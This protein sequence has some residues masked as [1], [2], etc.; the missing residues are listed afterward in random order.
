MITE[1]LN[2]LRQISE[3]FEGT[4]EELQSLF[5]C[6]DNELTNSKIKGSGLSGIQINIPYKVAII[7]IENIVK[8]FG[9]KE[10]VL[11]SYNLYNAEII[12]KEQLNIFKGEGCLSLPGQFGDTERYNLIEVK[13]GD[14]KIL[15]FSGYEAIVVQHE[16]DH[17]NGI[18]FIDRIM[19]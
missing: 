15:K 17:T 7:R 5:D 14:E 10:K 19:E 9:N 1:N 18:L 13:N 4:K 12:K 6:L 11:T 8:R 2:T 3:P 16:I